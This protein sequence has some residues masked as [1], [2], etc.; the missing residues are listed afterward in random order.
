MRRTALIVSVM[1]FTLS[2]QTLAD[3][4]PEEKASIETLIAEGR[5]DAKVSRERAVGEMAVRNLQDDVI[6]YYLG[7]LNDCGVNVKWTR[8]E[9][10]GSAFHSRFRRF[11]GTG[12]DVVFSTDFAPDW[13]LNKQKLIGDEPGFYMVVRLSIIPH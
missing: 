5:L 13:G 12:A 7:V 3:L 8:Q 6:R 9:S 2:M 1:L 11:K 10:A 4:T